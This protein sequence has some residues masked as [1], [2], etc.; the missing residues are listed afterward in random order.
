MSVSSHTSKPSSSARSAEPPSP[1]TL[2]DVINRDLST[3]KTAPDNVPTSTCGQCS[4]TKPWGMSIFCPQCG[5][6]PKLGKFVPIDQPHPEDQPVAILSV[7]EAWKAL[8]GWAWPIILGNLAIA[9]TDLSIAVAYAKTD[10]PSTVGFIQLTISALLLLPLHL[11]AYLKSI[12]ESDEIK[13]LDIF[14]KPRLVWKR[15]FAQLP[16]TALQVWLA[17]FSLGGIIFATLFLG[18][19][20]VNAIIDLMAVEKKKPKCSVASAITSAAGKKESDMSMEEALDEFA[21][22]ADP[23]GTPLDGPQPDAIKSAPCCIIGFTLYDETS[24]STLVLAEQQQG[25]WVYRGVVTC[26]NVSTEEQE[27]FKQA[28]R[29]LVR[30]QPVVSAPG[31]AFWM[32]PYVMCEVE[33]TARTP[34]GR[35]IDPTLKQI[36]LK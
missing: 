22:K 12:P 25:Y 15:T 20:N 5:W 33:Y 1:M 8:P 27:K 21:G 18:G 32:V 26:E 23:H 3:S 11:F 17:S 16:K 35:F 13:P 2:R 4:N 34:S 28:A 30:R 14:L 29:Q 31:T 24:L 6:Y 10:F 36:L 19:T 9:V 7:W